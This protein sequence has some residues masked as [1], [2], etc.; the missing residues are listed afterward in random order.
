MTKR[1]VAAVMLLALAGC[2]T[3]SYQTP[4]PGS[5]QYKEDRGDFFFWGLTGEKTVDLQAMCPQGVSRW[6]SEQTFVDGLIALVTLGIY[7][8]RHVTVE[9]AGGTAFRVETTWSGQPVAAA[10]LASTESGGTP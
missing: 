9:C 8:R 3:I 6:K 4:A 10:P 2:Y 5:G 1:L 7:V